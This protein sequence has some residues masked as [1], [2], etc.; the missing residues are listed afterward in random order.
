MKSSERGGARDAEDEEGLLQV[1]RYFSCL[2]AS[3][4]GFKILEEVF[5]RALEVRKLEVSVIRA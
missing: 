5:P 4:S 3:G 1:L 2:D